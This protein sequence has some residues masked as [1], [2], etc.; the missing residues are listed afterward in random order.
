MAQA[1]PSLDS[2]NDAKN[3]PQNVP[4]PTLTPYA[5]DA[6]R[7]QLDTQTSRLFSDETQAA[8]DFL[9]LGT[10]ATGMFNVISPRR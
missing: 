3:Y 2:C 4:D 1:L 10:S 6:I 8:L 9:D 5:L 7:H